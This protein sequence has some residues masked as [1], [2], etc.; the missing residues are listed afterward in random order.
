MLVFEVV[1]DEFIF[2]IGLLLV[3]VVVVVVNLVVGFVVGVGGMFVG[4]VVLFL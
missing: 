2:V 1:F 4:G 3:M